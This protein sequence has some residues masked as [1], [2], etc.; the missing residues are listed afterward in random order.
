MKTFR[1]FSMAALALVMAAC[2]SV[3]PPKRSTAWSAMPSPNIIMC[4]I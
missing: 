1:L 2:S 4:F 3:L